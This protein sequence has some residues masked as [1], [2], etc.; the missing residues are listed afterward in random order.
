MTSTLA[1]DRTPSTASPKQPE[2][3]RLQVGHTTTQAKGV[4]SVTA[5]TGIFNDLVCEI[6]GCR[7]HTYDRRLH[8]QSRAEQSMNGRSAE[9]KLKVEVQRQRQ[10]Q[11]HI[12]RGREEAQL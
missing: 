7:D 11:R 9:V 5:A 12:G 4:Q 1:Q 10:R 2:F 3:P 6:V 8:R